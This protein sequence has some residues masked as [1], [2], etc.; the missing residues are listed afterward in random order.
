MAHMAV[1]LASISLDRLSYLLRYV[2]V[3]ALLSF[4][5]LRLM[6]LD[7]KIDITWTG[8]VLGLRRRNCKSGD[9]SDAGRKLHSSTFSALYY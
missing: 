1:F 7:D 2:Q 4:R 6:K 8:A 5:D 9:Y 3:F